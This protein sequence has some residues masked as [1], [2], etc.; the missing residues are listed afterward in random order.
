MLLE[1][2]TADVEKIVRGLAGIHEGTH[3]LHVIIMGNGEEI[4][5]RA[6]GVDW[7]LGE[8]DGLDD[9]TVEI[10]QSIVITLCTAGTAMLGVDRQVATADGTSFGAAIVASNRIHRRNIGDV[11]LLA[12]DFLCIRL[13]DMIL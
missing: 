8:R 4:I 11:W 6:I 9:S 12:Q 3:L 5:L 13:Q 7:L 1:V 10:E 2:P